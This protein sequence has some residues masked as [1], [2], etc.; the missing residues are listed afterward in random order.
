MMLI[1]ALAASVAACE[2]TP[3]KT[4]SQGTTGTYKVGSPYQV[5]GTWY[6]PREQPNYDETGLASWYG[7][8]FNGKKTAN[9]EIFDQTTLSAAHK[10]LPMPVQVRV[11]NLENGRQLVLRVND[12][13]PFV[14]GRI[15]D[16]SAEAAG[17]LGFKGNG[18]AMVRVEY[19]GRSELETFYAAK[20]ETPIE[21]TRVTAAPV[22]DVA[23]DDL[24]PLPGVAVAKPVSPPV[25][26]A[27]ANV[28]LVTTV[29]VTS[30]PRMYVQA[31]SFQYRENAV[32]LKTRLEGEGHAGGDVSISRVSVSGSR[33]FRVQVGPLGS[34]RGADSLLARILAAGHVGAH[35]V[36]D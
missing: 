13:G 35:I 5:K 3:D 12:R 33:F 1:G 6:Y 23:S 16:V 25:V 11:T 14:P 17:L 9:G 31:G 19:L 22:R 26:V 20:P 34:V 32:R 21:H 8:N 7:P 29:P 30:A 28:P 27:E 18:T 10:T 15:I 24:T 36:I 2:T 4:T